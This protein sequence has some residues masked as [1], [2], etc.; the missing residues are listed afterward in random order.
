MLAALL[1]P[2]ILLQAVVD[3]I[4]LTTATASSNF[5][6]KIPNWNCARVSATSAP[7]SWLSIVGGQFRREKGCRASPSRQSPSSRRTVRRGDSVPSCD[8]TVLS[9]VFSSP[10][11]GAGVG[12]PLQRTADGRVVV[13]DT[14]P[15]S[16][17]IIAPDY[18]FS[19]RNVQLR[20]PIMVPQGRGEGEGSQQSNGL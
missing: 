8:W 18:N 19:C 14:R 5:F 10:R 9:S 6:I 16:G 20:L 11:R 1:C 4:G 17:R 7:H 15:R 12:L 3:F 2:G 13:R